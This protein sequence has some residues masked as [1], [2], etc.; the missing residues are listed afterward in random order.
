MSLA[1]A[2]LPADPDAL[3][4]LEVALQAELAD[5][6]LAIGQDPDFLWLIEVR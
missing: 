5:R 2:R 1:S 6:D 4:A 3:R